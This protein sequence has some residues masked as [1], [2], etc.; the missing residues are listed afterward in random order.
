VARLGTGPTETPSL[1]M[2]HA[3][4]PPKALFSAGTG[5]FGRVDSVDRLPRSARIAHTC[6]PYE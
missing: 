6:H 5:L 3:D 4:G 2:D 1:G